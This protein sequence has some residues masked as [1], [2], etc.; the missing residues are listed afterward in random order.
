M[1]CGTNHVIHLMSVTRPDGIHRG[2]ITKA[3][4]IEK[5]EVEERPGKVVLKRLHVRCRCDIL[6]HIHRGVYVA[7]LWSQ[8]L[9]KGLWVA[10]VESLWLHEG[11]WI[12]MVW[13]LWLYKG[14]L[15]VLALHPWLHFDF[16]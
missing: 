3:E 10:K 1:L 7:R 15:L 16:L 12:A 6:H 11:L 9:H 2:H 5:E 8:W 13:S 14:Y 4:C